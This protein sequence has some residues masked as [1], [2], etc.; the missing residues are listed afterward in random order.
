LTGSERRSYYALV[1]LPQGAT[2]T[3]L[4]IHWYAG[5]TLP[6]PIDGPCPPPLPTPADGLCVD[7]RIGLLRTDFT[8][9]SSEQFL[10][11]VHEVE[12]PL[13]ETGSNWTTTI[14]YATVDNASYAYY[15]WA[16][17]HANGFWLTGVQI[18][19]QFSEPY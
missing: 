4:T 16:G 8:G 6:A 13:G 12:T 17:I 9:L 10:A 7:G 2:I 11:E 14:D 3:K 18:E 5:R 15:V 1:Q 19:Y